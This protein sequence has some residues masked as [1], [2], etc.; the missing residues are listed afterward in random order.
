MKI[1][2]VLVVIV[3]AGLAGFTVGS[4]LQRRAHGREVTREAARQLII[5]TRFAVPVGDSPSTGAD[6]APVTIVVFSDFECSYCA[7]AAALGQQLHRD[8]G[9]AVRWVWKDSPLDIHKGAILAAEAARA[10]GAQGRFWPMHDKLM[11]NHDHLGREDLVRYANELSLDVNAFV[12]ALD[13]HTYRDAV[14][15]DRALARKV[16][17]RGIP[18]FFVN[19]RRLRGLPSYDQLKSVVAEELALAQE[20]RER[21]VAPQQIYA[22]TIAKAPASDATAQ[23][24]ATAAPPAPAPKLPEKDIV[25]ATNGAF[26]R[27]PARAPVTI[28]EFADY[29]CPYCAK[30]EPT[31]TQLQAQYGD[32]VRVVWKD[33]PL[34]FHDHA[35]LAAEAARA[36]G[37]QGKYFPMHDLLFQHQS[38]LDRPALESYAQSL[39]LDLARFR[40]ALDD[41]RH[42]A[43]I[44]TDLKQA[45]AI[46]DG[47][48]TP[49]FVINGR[50]LQGAQP[51][52]AFKTII[53]DE[54]AKTR[55]G[56][57]ATQAAAPGA[58]ARGI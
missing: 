44:D 52:E 38:A 57:Q 51:I 30:V 28:V 36:A 1:G 3:A 27:G 20:L 13:A 46:G 37:D 26:T 8:F 41:H 19:G 22:T 53:D 33:A 24:E 35:I 14:M 12:A 54:L 49:A 23:T 40:A 7:R 6:G 31:L 17:A 18:D 55:R 58:R 25:V 48:G 2:I 15:A 56:R 21:G 50:L 9:E 11:A 34:P 43:R 4:A 5:G 39:G 42:R 10:A 32:K 45:D 29:Q 47:L 16:G